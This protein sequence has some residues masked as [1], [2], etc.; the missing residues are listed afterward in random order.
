MHFESDVAYM[1][2]GLLLVTVGLEIA[3][4]ISGPLVAAPIFLLFS[5][6]I[7]FAAGAGRNLRTRDD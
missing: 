4:I 5:G 3:S 2:L 6:L 1:L 7:F